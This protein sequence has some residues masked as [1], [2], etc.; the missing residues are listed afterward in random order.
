MGPGLLAPES[1]AEK[2]CSKVLQNVRQFSC[3]W[4]N[5]FRKIPVNKP[6]RHSHEMV[7]AY[8]IFANVSIGTKQKKARNFSATKVRKQEVI[9]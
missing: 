6:I 3:I 2:Q 7:L 8:E 4:Y 1:T 9:D 5:S